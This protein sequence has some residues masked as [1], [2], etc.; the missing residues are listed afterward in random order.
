VLL[1]RYDGVWLVDFQS[2]R[3]GRLD[4]AGRERDLV[5]AA[6]FLRERLPAPLRLRALAAYFASAG[7][8]CRNRE[9]ERAQ[10]A[11]VTAAAPAARRRLVER[12]LGRWLRGSGLLALERTGEGTAL[13]SRALGLPA[14]S[15]AP[16]LELA[17]PSERVRTTWLAAARAHEHALPVVRPWR[18]ELAGAR[19][20]ATFLVPPGHPHGA[21]A[22]ARLLADRGLDAGPLST[23]EVPDGS[24]LLAPG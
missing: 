11:R 19:A 1:D 14:A 4:A 17:G 8:E 22:L 10:A 13:T 6:G 20:R 24:A 16:R 18:L 2:A 12:G 7:H 21:P 23:R 5:R 3:R 9:A 15:D